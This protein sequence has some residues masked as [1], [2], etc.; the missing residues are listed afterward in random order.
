MQTTPV[1]FP[2][3]LKL[4][5]HVGVLQSLHHH[6]YLFAELP[7]QR[8]RAGGLRSRGVPTGTQANS[9]IDQT[10]EAEDSKVFPTDAPNNG[11]ILMGIAPRPEIRPSGG[12]L[13]SPF[14]TGGPRSP[15]P[16]RPRLGISH[17]TGAHLR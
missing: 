8:R 7:N 1:K 12:S 16:G 13:S 6:K 3:T 11:H 2:L 17:R 5:K 15:G 10:L 4:A 14:R 9:L